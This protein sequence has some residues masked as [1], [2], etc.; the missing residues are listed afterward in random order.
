ML[1][2]RQSDG[3]DISFNNNQSKHSEIVENELL[4]AAE[5]NGEEMEMVPDGA[6]TPPSP[7]LWSLASVRLTI[8]I[9]LALSLAI[10]G[11]MRSN[12]NMAMVCMVNKTA[13]SLMAAQNDQ[14]NG[15]F[16]NA[17]FSSPSPVH[18][19]ECAHLTEQTNG[20]KL[21]D[22]KIFEGGDLVISKQMQ[23]L[24]FTS[25]Y[26]GGLLII[27]PGSFLCDWLGPTHLVF[28]GALL[29]VFGTFFTPFVVRHLGSVAFLVVRFLMG[30]GQVNKSSA[31]FLLY[32]FLCFWAFCTAIAISTTGNQISVVLA[33][34]V[35]AELCVVRWLGGWAASFYIYGLIGVAFCAVWML[36]VR[37]YPS[38]SK[39]IRSDELRLIELNGGHS[40]V[41]QKISPNE[42]P[43][44]RIL[45]SMVVWST[46][47]SSFSQNF[48]N[49]G[50]VVYLPTYYHNVLGMDLTSNGLMSAL[51]FIVQLF[52]K[53]LFA[54]IADWLK[55]R[56]LMSSTS[57]TKLFNLIA[58]FG[59]GLCFVLLSLCD[60]RTP[61]LAISLAVCAIGISS[62]FIPGYNT[63]VVCIAPRYTSSIA[64]FSRLLGQI[65]SVVSPYGIGII[66]ANGTKAAWQ[67]S[68]LGMAAIL[69][70]TG[71]LFQF[72][73]SATVQEWAVILP[74]HE[75]HQQ[76]TKLDAGTE[77]R[78]R[79]QNV[80]E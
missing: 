59:S 20:T 79:E 31:L 4:T 70:S 29:N 48:M 75:T 72:F 30:C 51:P 16:G 11:L 74:A 68:F 10:E 45:C 55:D 80:E 28:Y 26:L 1:R 77:G 36:L 61:Y 50:I 24:I 54:A 41:S 38:Q 25:F 27:L 2:H 60:C 22:P 6:V 44:R 64:S 37:D 14:S 58:C 66:V 33:M 19:A 5:R 35:T 49:V 78:R 42:V 43:W 21:G 34:F 17:S 18:L 39:Y 3:D 53:I 15:I 13:I 65:A 12:I 46:G 76:L 69:F 52:T 71:I 73:G 8:A 63:S 9:A 40:N 56:R 23:S 32:H 7:P 47:F 67:F 57:V 62:G